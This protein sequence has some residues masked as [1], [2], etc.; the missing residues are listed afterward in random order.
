M[1]GLSDTPKAT[2][3]NIMD[4]TEASFMQDVIEA[5]KTVPVIVDFW[6]QWCGPCKTLGPSIEAAVAKADGRVKLVKIDV[7]ANPAIAAQLQVQSLPMVYAF[8]NG[9]PVDGFQGAIPPSEVNAFVDK[10]VALGPEPDNGLD[11]AVEAAEGMMTDGEYGDAAET[12]SAIL[13]ED[14]M[15]AV[16]YGGLVRAHIALGELDQAEAVLN[17]APAEISND[18]AIDAAHA[19]LTLARKAEGAGPVDELRAAVDADPDNH[20]ARIDLAIALM[21]N[22]DATG[23]VDELLE[24]FR[25]DREWNDGAARSELFTIFDAL[26][27]TDPVVLNG[28]RKLSSMIFA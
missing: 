2:T 15:H 1:L 13:S 11:D 16:A 12:F 19:Q 20:K 8:F 5:S 9:Q 7:D 22:D 10:I 26:A 17:G 4:G 24:S 23:A 18:A 28:R 14:G 27:P 3:T 21:A 6:A 25:R